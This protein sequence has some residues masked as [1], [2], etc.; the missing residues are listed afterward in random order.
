M[1][2]NE[3]RSA[4]TPYGRAIVS[5]GWFVLNL[6]DA[7]AAR[8]EQKGGAVY[9]LEAQEAPFRDF[10]VHVHVLAP[11]QPNAMYHAE[12]GQE[13]FLVLAG[14]CVLLV[15]E[16]ERVLRQWDYFHCPPNTRHVFVGG[17]RPC[18]VLMIGLRPKEETLYYPVSALAAKHGASAAA[19]TYVPGEAYADWPGEFVPVRL[20]W[21]V[22]MDDAEA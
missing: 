4:E 15:E 18:A 12:S 20:P 3:A 14:E 6:G 5:D 7:L 2:V 1:S 19:E 16:E 11:G 8:N 17:D 22:V 10:G 13:G 21:P 9:P